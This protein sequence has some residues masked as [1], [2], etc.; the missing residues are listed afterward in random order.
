[1]PWS[2]WARIKWCCRWAWHE[3][4][5]RQPFGHHAGNRIDAAAGG[6]ADDQLQFIAGAGGWRGWQ[7]KRRDADLHEERQPR[8]GSNAS[9]ATKLHVCTTHNRSTLVA[10]LIVRE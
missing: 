6:K 1:M 10:C 9:S 2:R 4:P 3:P 8:G 7:Q 5:P